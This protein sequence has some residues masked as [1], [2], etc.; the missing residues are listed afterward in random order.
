M[1]L[2]DVFTS[3]DFNEHFERKRSEILEIPLSEIL[4]LK[5][6]Y[7]SLGYQSLDRF[8]PLTFCY[9]SESIRIFV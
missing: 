8:R 7:R 5:V 1:L 9:Y 6:G 2:T 3:N 4:N